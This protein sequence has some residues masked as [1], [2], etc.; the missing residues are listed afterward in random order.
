MEKLI[1]NKLSEAAKSW[2]TAAAL[3]LLMDIKMEAE[4]KCPPRV[5]ADMRSGAGKPARLKRIA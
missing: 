2:N 3:R 4:S 5:V 1:E